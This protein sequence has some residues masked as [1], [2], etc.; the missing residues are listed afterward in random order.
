MSSSKI[1]R[2]YAHALA[3]LCRDEGNHAIIAKQLDGFAQLYEEAAEFRDAMRSPV[4][5]LDDKRAILAQVVTRAMGA[6]TT[7]RFL[8]TLLD[9]GRL[10]EL[11]GVSEAFNE[12]LDQVDGRMRAE[13]TSAIPMEAGDL[14]RVQTS[15]E[16]LTSKKVTVTATVDPELLGGVRIQMGNVVLDGSVRTQL[17]R[18]RDQLLA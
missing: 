12:I 1:A 13:V 14:T 9:A 8:Y 7:R 18:M 17:N 16:R 5:S 15:L 2:R 3:D 4:F 6:D 11:G 10:D